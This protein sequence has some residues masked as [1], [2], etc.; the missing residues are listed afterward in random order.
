M[1]AWPLAALLACGAAYAPEGDGGKEWAGNLTM[2]GHSL[3]EFEGFAE[4][5]ALVTVR[6]RQDS[7]EF[8]FTYANP[9]A[10]R[11]LTRGRPYP[12]GAVFA[13]VSYLLSGD[14]A[15]PSSLLPSKVARYQLMVKDAA[16][17]PETDGWA[18]ALFDA[19]RRTFPGPPRERAQAC[20]ACHRI[21]LGKGSVFSEP[22]GRTAASPSPPSGAGSSLPAFRSIP[23]GE[24]P[25]RLHPLL[26]A[27]TALL[28][29][30]TGPLREHL[31]D[32]T[33]HEIRPFLAQEALR[34]AL[35]AALVG[36]DGRSFA[37][38]YRDAE[39]SVGCA[40][41]F[42]MVALTS[43]S[44]TPELPYADMGEGDDVAVQTF[45]HVKQ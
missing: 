23:A 4:K 40:G 36:A 1:K 8:R 35:P 41:A 15:F 44:E 24:L 14:P 3:A 30:V 13:K 2:N 37:L 29:S 21:V 5:W 6:Y 33:L 11:A 32:G 45:C 43:R 7:G 38:V 27:G 34:A 20:N 19:G 22:I 18:Y 17:N 42:A 10:F 16:A 39:A 31:F 12:D 26:P 9:S 28:R 25:A